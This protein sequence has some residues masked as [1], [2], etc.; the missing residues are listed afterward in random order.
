MELDSDE[1]ATNSVDFGCVRRLI[2]QYES[3]SAGK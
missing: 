1:A 3:I 2:Q